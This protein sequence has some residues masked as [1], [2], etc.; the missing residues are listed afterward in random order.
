MS[1]VTPT[2]LVVGNTTG[3]SDINN[4]NVSWNAA[5]V[6]GAIA[7]ANFREDGIDR[8]VI[9]QHAVYSTA[10]GATNNFLSTGTL[11]TSG[12]GGVTATFDFGALDYIGPVTDL[13]SSTEKIIIGYSVYGTGTPSTTLTT[14]LEVSTDAVAWVLVAETSRTKATR[15][16]PQPNGSF[17]AKTVWVGGTPG[18]LYFRI[19]VVGSGAFADFSNGTLYAYVLLE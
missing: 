16:V 13:G 19:R 2:E 12:A 3:A 9:A 10:R 7:A 6:A 5:T 11:T 18:S 4:T 8:R 1:T 14:H 17:S 15:T